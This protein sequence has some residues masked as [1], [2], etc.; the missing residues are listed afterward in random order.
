MPPLGTGI[1]Q[2]TGHCTSC[3]SIPIL[4]DYKLIE[5]SAGKKFFIVSG[6]LKSYI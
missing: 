6:E 1:S 5:D 4:G 3:N 2:F